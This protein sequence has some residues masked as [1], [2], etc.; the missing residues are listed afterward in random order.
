MTRE[1]LQPHC[2]VCLK[3]FKRTDQVHTD[4]F[5][6]QIQHAKCF[7]W[8]PEFINDT[9]T[10][11]EVVNKYPDYKKS[12]IVSDNPVTNLPLVAAHKV[13]KKTK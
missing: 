5:G 12:F 9:G 11:E 2:V 7:M 3:P 6:M 13:R 10:Y 8:K 4:T 1:K